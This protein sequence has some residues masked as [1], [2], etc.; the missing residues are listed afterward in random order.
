MFESLSPDNER[1]AALL[2]AHPMHRVLRSLPPLDALPLPQAEGRVRRAIAP[3]C[4]ITSLDPASG[5]II[6]LAMCEVS[7]D[8]RGRIVHIRHIHEWFDAPGYPLPPEIDGAPFDAKDALKARGYRWDQKS[9]RWR[10]EV[11]IKAAE[12]D[13][14]WLAAYAT[15]HNPTMRRITRHQRHRT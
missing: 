9:H 14:A 3:N 4:E 10:I 8:A 5:H 12:G 2:E 1:A 6:E 11:T 7:S 15:C 13:R